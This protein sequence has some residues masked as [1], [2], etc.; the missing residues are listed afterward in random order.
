MG[1][2]E[3]RAEKNVCIPV[4]PS[5]SSGV[6]RGRG[7]ILQDVHCAHNQGY[8]SRVDQLHL[9]RHWRAKG[10]V[11]TQQVPH[12]QLDRVQRRDDEHFA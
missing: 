7:D 11:P 12:V 10:G 9:L 6:Q 2:T 1:E 4:A 3:R 5:T 8:V